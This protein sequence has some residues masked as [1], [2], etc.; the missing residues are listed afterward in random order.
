MRV[1]VSTVASL[2]GGKQS[3]S[4]IKTQVIL[5]RDSASVIY[6]ALKALQTLKL[7]R[8][9]TSH[10]TGATCAQVAANLPAFLIFS[11]H[12]CSCTKQ[13]V[14][15]NAAPFGPPHPGQLVCNSRQHLPFACQSDSNPSRAFSPLLLHPYKGVSHPQG[16]ITTEPAPQDRSCGRMSDKYQFKSSSH[17]H[18]PLA[19]TLAA[20]HKRVRLG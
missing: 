20:A 10:A 12:H 4:C 8:M 7:K 9:R 17:L 14:A 16:T 15:E 1:L 5:V 13:S 19:D 6:I 18:T 11:A 3:L 2:S